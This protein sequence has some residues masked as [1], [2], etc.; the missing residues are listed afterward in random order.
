MNLN[1][2]EGEIS[3]E[4]KVTGLRADIQALRALAVLLVVVFHLWPKSLTGGFVGVDVFF[5]ISG[6]LITS[7]L[8]RDSGQKPSR[9]IRFWARRVRRLMPASFLV[10]ATTAITV[11]LAV[12][13]FFKRDW[14]VEV[15]AS[16]A[17]GEN[18]LLARKS[19][20][21]MAEGAAASPT[22]HFWSLSVEEQFYIVWP[23]LILAITVLL[24]RSSHEVQKRVM[25]YSLGA[26]VAASLAYSYWLT[27]QDASTAY[28][29][30]PVRAWEFGAGGLLAFALHKP[31]KRLAQVA[32]I[33]GLVLIA[34]SAVALTSSLPFPGVIAL[35]PVLGAGLVI[36]GR[37]DAGWIDR[38]F[39]F[40]PIGWL[41]SRSYSIYLWHWP[42][43]ILTP[44]V[45][46]AEL[47]F[48]NRLAV[49]AAA[50][51]LAEL[52]TRFVEQK[53][54]GD[55]RWSKARPRNVFA[56]L[57]LSSLVIGALSIAG[58][59]ANTSK[60][61]QDLAAG[62]STL[63]SFPDDFGYLPGCEDIAFTQSKPQVCE[64]GNRDSTVKLA[65]VGDSHLG[66]YVATLDA[67]A[68]END[69]SIDVIWKP[70]C[71][72]SAATRVQKQSIVEACAAW[73]VAVQK[74]LKANS[75]QV[76]LTTAKSGVRW[77]T[78][79][80]ESNDE[81]A[82]SGFATVWQ[83]LAQSGTS[84]VV[85]RDNPRARKDLAACLALRSSVEC[86]LERSVALKPDPQVAAVLQ[87]ASP[88][89]S[90][91]DITDIYCPESRCEPVQAGVYVYRDNQHLTGSFVRTLQPLLER[92]L[93]DVLSA[94]SK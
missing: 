12:P 29:S 91:I 78:K 40:A 67:L 53:F 59:Q 18:W 6:F 62:K 1:I 24:R 71:P 15:V 41:G 58:I 11:A 56:A 52:T 70:A 84:V 65:A 32:T 89:V 55:G 81:V 31:N 5:V 49:F 88:R 10:I 3:A 42:L 63:D 47:T 69:W 44:Y 90:L 14:L 60:I 38:V 43:I 57:A 26:V 61:N 87:V 72:Y 17:Y 16:T 48:A 13:A 73:N 34:I 20:D 79:A 80:A 94:A 22:Q 92:H 64:L 8:V 37:S 76:V 39:N 82:S 74:L 66:A 23:L 7:H 25:L 27:A 46:R 83:E 51:L 36:W 45:I 28:F 33:L 19:V 75:Y 77:E 93:Q 2:P 30:T 54:I 9:V 35:V 50:L 21:Y 4:T 68:K 86:S 85:I